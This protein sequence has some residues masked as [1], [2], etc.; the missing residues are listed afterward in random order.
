[1][2]DEP[3]KKRSDF[4]MD[5]AGKG[6]RQWKAYQKKHGLGE[7]AGG[8]QDTRT[9]AADETVVRGREAT[10]GSLARRKDESHAAHSARVVARRKAAQE[11]RE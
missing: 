2:A 3:L 8:G 7:Y 4:P 6:T 10:G 11:A 9:E 5:L 1:M